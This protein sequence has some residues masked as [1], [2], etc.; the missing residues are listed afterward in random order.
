MKTTDRSTKITWMTVIRWFWVSVLFSVGILQMTLGGK[1]LHYIVFLS[2]FFAVIC[3][4]IL[5]QWK[6]D[7]HNKWVVLFQLLMD[8]LF[9]TVIV[10]LTGGMSSCFAWVY[11]IGII[12]ASLLLPSEGTALGGL[13]SSFALLLL[14]ILY[15][16]NIIAPIGVSHI[17]V[18][19]AIVYVLSYT[20][21]FF[22]I[23]YLTSIIASQVNDKTKTD[24]R[25][26]LL[27]TEIAAFNN[28]H[29]EEPQYYAQVEQLVDIA[30][31]IAHIDHDI[32]TP[33]CVITLSLSRVRR[34]GLETNSESLI[35]S[36]N[37][38]TEAVNRITDILRALD[39]LKN[40]PLLEY[41]RGG[42]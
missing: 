9:S 2:L 18:T 33:L 29:D 26:A 14:I 20:G 19:G 15:R 40:C 1:L 35:K 4:N 41:R 5:V 36:N 16:T 11:I 27:E 8:V 28:S 39:E 22:G 23:G 34:I 7:S 3:V 21:L 42:V 24:L 17:E 25:I 13:A 6:A 38:I 37:E 30:K 32:N 10:H 12:T 31:R